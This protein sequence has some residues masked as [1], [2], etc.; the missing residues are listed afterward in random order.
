M[1]DNCSYTK[2]IQLVSTVEEDSRRAFLWKLFGGGVASFFT[3]VG[4]TA[5]KAHNALSLGSAS[6]ASSQAEFAH[7]FKHFAQLFDS[8]PIESKRRYID[9]LNDSRIRS[10]NVMAAKQSIELNSNT[11]ANQ[12]PPVLNAVFFTAFRVAGM[13]YYDGEDWSVFLPRVGD[14]V[15][16]FRQPS[17]SYDPNAIEIFSPSGLKIG[18]VP[19]KKNKYPARLMD[20]GVEFV[21]RVSFFDADEES[22]KRMRVEM[23]MRSANATRIAKRRVGFGTS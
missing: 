5:S 9:E 8:L 20:Q 21:G 17:N 22:W 12:L 14:S 23:W 13:Q 11:E 19:M 4:A 3:S 7:N 2:E 6:I 18:F 10:E 15:N 1:K 16:F